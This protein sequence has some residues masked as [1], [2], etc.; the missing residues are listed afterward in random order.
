ML[1]LALEKTSQSKFADSLDVRIFLDY[2]VDKR[3][4]EVEWVRDTYLPTAEIFRAKEHIKV[5]SGCWNILNAL[6]N[7]YESGADLI[8]LVEEDVLTDPETF[9]T[10]H[11][12][13]HQ[14]DDYF[15]TC[16]RRH[17]R[18]PLDFYSNPGTCYRR[19]AL[20]Q[21][22]PHIN[23]EYFADTT[24][25]LNKYFPTMIGTD[26][27]LDDGLI[28]KV[29]R[30]VKGKVLCADPPVAFHQGFNYYNRLDLYMNPGRT[31]PEKILELRKMLSR[32]NPSDRYAQ[33]FEPFPGGYDAST[34]LAERN[35]AG[36][37]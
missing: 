2:T 26:G 32:I 9:W 23:D 4:D 16:G 21:I 6:K 8:F 31:L 29:Q 13:R 36:K 27:T 15:V 5:P 35:S 1:A 19:E 12:E 24:K 33:D 20:A 28:R 30:S 11:W 25:Y 18:M 14:K 7:G 17:G 3:A 10:W 22:I 37:V 34:S